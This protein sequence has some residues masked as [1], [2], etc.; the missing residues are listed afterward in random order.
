MA[1]ISKVTQAKR[2]VCV[3]ACVQAWAQFLYIERSVHIVF[4][5]NHLHLQLLLIVLI[6]Y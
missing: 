5:D 3:R 1:P 6:A 2:Y 4:N